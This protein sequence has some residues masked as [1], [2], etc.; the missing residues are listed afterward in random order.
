MENLTNVTNVA[1]N[2][3][4]CLVFVIYL[5]LERSTGVESVVSSF[6]PVVDENI[7]SFVT[8]KIHILTM[9]SIRWNHVDD[10]L[11]RRKNV[12]NLLLRLLKL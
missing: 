9:F 3:P 6:T 11:C 12:I 4:L 5:L 10:A 2:R 8:T 1:N 7:W